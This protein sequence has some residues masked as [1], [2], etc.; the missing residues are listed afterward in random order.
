[1][2]SIA[3][4]KLELTLSRYALFL[5]V[6]TTYEVKADTQFVDTT[7]QYR[8]GYTL[9]QMLINNNVCEI[10]YS[11]LLVYSGS[12]HEFSEVRSYCYITVFKNE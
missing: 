2:S 4:A 7:T 3:V 9:S 12:C 11:G 1:M 6:F 10:R 8:I 5:I